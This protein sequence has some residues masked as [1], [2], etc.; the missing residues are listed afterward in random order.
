MKAAP[1]YPML[2]PEVCD[3][4]GYLCSQLCPSCFP[5]WENRGPWSS[6]ADYAAWG[7]QALWFWAS[8]NTI[9]VTSWFCCSY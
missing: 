4:A 7:I 1:G 9:C 5:K 3:Q 6:S 2:L 8:G